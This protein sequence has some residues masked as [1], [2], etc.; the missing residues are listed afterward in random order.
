[1]FTGPDGLPILLMVAVDHP[2]SS[3]RKQPEGARYSE[4]ATVSVISADQEATRSFYEGVLG[5]NM[6]SGAEV[7]PELLDIANE[8]VDVPK[9]TR[10][11]FAVFNSPPDPSGKY[12][13]IHFFEGTG[14]R[15]E[16]R[17]RPGHL[18]IS[19]YT[20]DVDDLAVFVAAAGPEA[21][22]AGPTEARV[23]EERYR[24]A[25]LAG[26]NEERFELRERL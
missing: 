8:L 12:L 4:I 18:G 2:E 1:M 24:I 17:M 25:I 6:R 21:V 3:H 22:V 19:L 10:M 9:G 13:L 26:P 15:L 7:G 14:S 11:H 16:G 5:M 20:H 23:G